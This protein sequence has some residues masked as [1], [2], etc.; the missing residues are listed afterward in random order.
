M[1]GLTSYAKK[2]D[3]TILHTNDFHCTFNRANALLKTIHSLR[4]AYPNSI[5]LDA[6]DMFE[7]KVPKVLT[8]HGQIVV[9]F[10]NRAEY[11]A[12]TPGDNAFDVLPL[13]DLERCIKRFKFPV[14]SSNLEKKS[15]NQLLSLPYFIFNCNGARLGVIGVYDEEPL[16]MAGIKILPP[17]KTLHRYISM[18]KNKV[19]CVI[20]LSHCGISQDLKLAKQIDGID[21]IVG[22]SSEIELHNPKKAGDTIIVQAGHYGMYVGALHICIDTDKNTISSYKGGLIPTSSDLD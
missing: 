14:V 1:S 8:T 12:M 13:K 16:D 9:D 21:V 2:I 3:V 20:A 17:K 19:D 6:G 11:D 5:L 10:M 7:S 18:L 4:K 22:G 15:N